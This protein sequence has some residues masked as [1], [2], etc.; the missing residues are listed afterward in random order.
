MHSYSMI[1]L[2]SRVP[3]MQRNVQHVIGTDTSDVM[4]KTSMVFAAQEEQLKRFTAPR[5]VTKSA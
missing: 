5:V 4:H 1:M 3:T 2:N